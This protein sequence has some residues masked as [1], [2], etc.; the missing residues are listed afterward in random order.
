MNQRD[1]R[2]I[3]M[4]LRGLVG[5]L[6]SAPYWVQRRDACE[7]LFKIARQIILRLRQAARDE[8]RDVAHWGQQACRQLTKDLQVT[9]EELELQVFTD[10]ENAKRDADLERADDEDS[11]PLTAGQLTAWLAEF[12]KEERGELKPREGGATITLPVRDGRRQTIYADFSKSTSEGAP[13]ALFYSVCGHAT[14]EAYDWALQ[15]NTALSR[16]AF[17]VIHHQ[18]KPVLIMLMRRRFS[19]IYLGTLGEKLRYIA[20]KADVAESRLTGSDRH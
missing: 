19:E 10:W 5:Q 14:P 17:G 8:D 6:Q 13:S 12:A 1:R 15:A 3:W 16:G 7:V 2:T 18:N 20:R 4:G 11:E 9:P